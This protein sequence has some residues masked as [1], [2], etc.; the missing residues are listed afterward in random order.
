MWGKLSRV[1]RGLVVGMLL[2]VTIGL[3]QYVSLDQR[4]GLYFSAFHHRTTGDILKIA[5]AQ[6]QNSSSRFSA[7]F[8]LAH[9]A[10]G[11]TILIADK[12]SGNDDYFVERLFAFG[13]VAHVRHVHGD[14][15]A[16]ISGFD[17]LDDAI[18]RGPGGFRGA[19][20]AI[21]IPGA[22]WRSIPRTYLERMYRG[23]SVVTI[24]PR[25]FLIVQVPDPSVGGGW[26]YRWEFVD[27]ALLPEGAPK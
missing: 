25:T 19:P 4:A 21:A 24:E 8:A 13:D 15:L 10:P 17:P 3:V 26:D 14:A 9:L 1:G 12:G 5:W 18:A 27:T 6:D 16:A 20:W 22:D 11:S 23:D 2:L 7:F